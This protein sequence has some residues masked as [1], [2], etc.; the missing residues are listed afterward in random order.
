MS[1]KIEITADNLN[2][3]SGKVMA[4]AATMHTAAAPA[5]VPD[6]NPAPAKPK[7]KKADP[8]KEPE[9]E[10]KP[11][12]VDPEVVEVGNDASSAEAEPSSG[13]TPETPPAGEPAL[14]F[15]KD[16]AP[17]VLAVV[18]AKGKPVVQEILSQFGVE[19]AS[20]LDEAQW[21]ELV[22]ALEDAI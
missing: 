21:P 10:V 6:E 12:A 18:A 8:K 19:R 14:D 16:I 3:L 5:F 7:A 2:E 9:I 22:A 11:E 1:Y 17:K 20:Q 13:A 15:D 4:L